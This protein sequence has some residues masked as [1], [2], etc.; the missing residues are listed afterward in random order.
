MNRIYV[1]LTIIVIT[2]L[3]FYSCKSSKVFTQGDDADV[4]DV[5][6]QELAVSCTDWESYSTSGKLT[7]S[8]AA[9]F[10]TSI[11]LKMVRGKCVAISIRPFLGIEVAKVFVNN[12]SAVVVNKIHKVYTAVKLEQF[13]HILPASI[14]TIQ[15]I[16]LARP[17]TISDGTLSETNAKKFNI[18]Q[19]DRGYTLS[20]RKTSKGISYQFTINENKQMEELIVTPDNSSK[21]YTAI[22]SDFATEKPCSEASR[23]KLDAIISG[24]EMSLQLYLNPSKTKWNSTIDESEIVGG[25]YRKISIAEMIDI[26]KSM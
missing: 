26:I 22:Y 5:A 6:L 10:S 7:L 2:V 20:P 23:I 25:S 14:N 16:I 8:G 19:S 18:E 15:D 3:S 24:K 1:I 12:D 9:S 4:P 13:K 21:N 17:F 11:Q